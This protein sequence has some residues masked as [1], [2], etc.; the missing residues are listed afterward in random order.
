MGPI[1]SQRLLK[2]VLVLLPQGLGAGVAMPHKPGLAD[3]GRANALIEAGELIAEQRLKITLMGGHH[4]HQRG[5][6]PA[7][8][9][10]VASTITG[11]PAASA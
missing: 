1:D 7:A 6:P 5:Q 2:P 4:R 11:I 3:A 10:L 8:A 9:G